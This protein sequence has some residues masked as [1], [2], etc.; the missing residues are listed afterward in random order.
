[1]FAAVHKNELEIMSYLD[2]SILIG[3]TF[4]E[5][6]SAVLLLK[7]LRHYS[8]TLFYSILFY[9]ILFYSKQRQNY[10]QGIAKLFGMLEAAFSGVR[11]SPLNNF[12]FIKSKK[13][14]IEVGKRFLRHLF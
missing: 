10:N 12:Y 7:E 2:D 9:P 1:M 14:S 4:E 6:K 8:K 5:C 3:D 11:F 13:G